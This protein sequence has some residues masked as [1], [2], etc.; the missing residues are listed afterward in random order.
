MMA[1]LRA[2]RGNL[3]GRAAASRLLRPPGTPDLAG[4]RPGVLA[5]IP[6]LVY[7]P[8]QHGR[9]ALPNSAASPLPGIPDSAAGRLG[10]IPSKLLIY[11]IF[12]ILE[13]RLSGAG[14][15]FLP[16]GRGNS[17]DPLVAQRGD[18][19]RVVAEG[20]EDFVGVLAEQRCRPAVGARGL[21]E[22]DRRRRQRQR[23]AQPGVADLFEE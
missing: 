14:R 18:F 11:G 3:D 20:A 19:A 10:Q 6:M 12:P 16:D 4:G 2:K 17:D 5:M 1:S 7:M 21:G 13:G 15:D 22:L 8:I 23:V 9:T